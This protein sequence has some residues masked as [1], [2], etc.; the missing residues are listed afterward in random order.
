MK[1][2]VTMICLFLAT[3]NFTHAQE[4]SSSKDTQLVIVYLEDK[5]EITGELISENETEIVINSASLGLLTFQQSEVKRVVYLDGK[6]RMPNPNPTRYFIGQSAYTHEKG[7]GY[8]QNIYGLFN[9]VSYGITDRL[10][11]IGGVELIS[12]YSG[13]PILFANAKYGI[14]VAPKLNLAASVSYLTVAGSLT[15]LSAGTI[16]GLVTYGSKEHHLTVGTGY[17]FA[18]GEIDSSGVLTIGGIT[19]LN[20][21]FALLTENYILTSGEEA[22]ISGGVRYI[23]KK[24]TIDLMYFEGGFPAIDIVLK[25]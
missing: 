6:G 19:R 8:Y 20:K 4:Q 21:R 16:N 7:E 2:M 12:L 18:N 24:L 15:E 23:A 17:A 25:L 13:N 10:S 9:L 11:V 3:I 22:I 14:P 1:T 5:S